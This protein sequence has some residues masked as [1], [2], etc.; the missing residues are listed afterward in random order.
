MIE[1]KDC[2]DRCFAEVME[3]CGLLTEITNCDYT[4]P[5]YKPKG[6][7]DWVRTD[8]KLYAPEEYAETFKPTED[9]HPVW[10]IK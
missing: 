3:Q 5:F 2:T 9:K 10:R 6:C 4:C 7:R 8:D 1:L